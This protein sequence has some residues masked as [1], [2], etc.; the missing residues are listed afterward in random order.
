MAKV[1]EKLGNFKIIGNGSRGSHLVLNGHNIAYC[2]G[3]FKKTH[4][5]IEKWISKIDKRS[6]KRS[7]K[8]YST[9]RELQREDANL[10]NL[11]DEIGK[12]RL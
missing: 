8:I 12:V 4:G 5:S 2:F 11:M 10:Q 7:D 1:L 3:D 6:H 9:I